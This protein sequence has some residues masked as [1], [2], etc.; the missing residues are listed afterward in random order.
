MANKKNNTDF[1]FG[2]MGNFGSY[3]I[4]AYIL[5][6]TCSIKL[7]KQEA[8]KVHFLL[9]VAKYHLI[10]LHYLDKYLYLSPL[11]WNKITIIPSCMGGAGE[12]SPMNKMRTIFLM[13]LTQLVCQFSTKN[14]IGH[15]LWKLSNFGQ[16]DIRK[17]ALIFFVGGFAPAPPTCWEL[18]LR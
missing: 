11:L 8:K 10:Y 16:F 6:P 17:I 15:E 5:R 14:L 2:N 13:S 12:N 1:Y 9:F 4:F 18:G 3:F 7:T